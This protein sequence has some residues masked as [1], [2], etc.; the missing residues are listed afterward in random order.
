MGRILPGERNSRRLTCRSIYA[1]IYS[2]TI[3]DG[4]QSGSV[5]IFSSGGLTTS[6]I[7]GFTITNGYAAQ[8]G[9]IYCTNASPVITNCIITGNSTF[10]G[11]DRGVDE[12]GPGGNGG[13]GAGI[14]ASVDSSPTIISCTVSNN[15][16]GRGGN[17]RSVNTPGY[18]AGHGG[19]GG[20]IFCYS[21]TIVQ[22]LISGNS[23]GAGGASG[24]QSG[25][26]GNG[27]GVF[28][29]SAT[30]AESVIAGNRTGNWAVLLHVPRAR[31]N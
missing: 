7:Q 31:N 23:T 29:Y 28:C 16:T 27:G 10:A 13:D 11:V 8:G 4:S 17:A 24:N 15:I 1:R 9:G 25:N 22:S 30:I 20:G 26:G 3:I 21:A 14:Y 2:T 5:V 19:N 18:P 12:A 6:V